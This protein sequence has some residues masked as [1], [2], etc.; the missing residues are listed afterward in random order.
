MQALITQNLALVFELYKV[1]YKYGDV[2]PVRMLGLEKSCSPVKT[3]EGYSTINLSATY[4][5]SNIMGGQSFQFSRLRFFSLDKKKGLTK[6]SDKYCE[7]TPQEVK[8]NP[9]SAI[10]T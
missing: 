8:M 6:I 7:I 3:L 10:L 4:A 2:E 5:L 9:N 1:E